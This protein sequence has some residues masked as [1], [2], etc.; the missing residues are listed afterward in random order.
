MALCLFADL[1]AAKLCPD[2][3]TF[4]AAVS[5]CEKASEWSMALHLLGMMKSETNTNLTSFGAAISA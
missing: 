2:E 4:G 3:V 5:A 1:P